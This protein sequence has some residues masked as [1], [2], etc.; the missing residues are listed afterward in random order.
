MIDIYE[1]K[2]K[3]YRIFSE[4]KMKVDGEWID[5]I[6]YQTLYYNEDGWIWV[7]S[8]DEFFKLFELKNK[9]DWKKGRRW[10]ENN[11]NDGTSGISEPVRIPFNNDEVIYCI[12]SDDYYGF[13]KGKFYVANYHPDGG[14]GS[15]KNDRNIWVCDKDSWELFIE[16]NKWRQLLAYPPPSPPP[17]QLIREGKD[18]KPMNR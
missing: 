2:G 6:I 9:D 1:Y 14:Q 16:E 4:S 18:P 5:C 7:R 11:L 15:I 3:Q 12:K 10:G 17:S 8:R 13:T